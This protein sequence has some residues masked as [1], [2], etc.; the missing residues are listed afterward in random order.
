MAEAEASTIE[1]SYPGPSGP[2]LEGEKSSSGPLKRT[3]T[4]K[5]R[6]RAPSN[7]GSPPGL[8]NDLAACECGHTCKTRSGLA[9]HRKSCGIVNGQ[10]R[11]RSRCQYCDAAFDT[12]IGVRQHERRAHPADY[13]Q[14]LQ[15][16]LDNP[17]QEWEIY[18]TLAGI[19][20]S[21]RKGQPFIAR[22]VE[23]TGLPASK[24]DYIRRRKPVYR[25][26]LEAARS[27]FAAASAGADDGADVSVSGSDSVSILSTL[28]AA[29]LCRHRPHLSLT[30]ALLVVRPDAAPPLCL[31]PRRRAPSPFLL[32]LML[33][34]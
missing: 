26:Y 27:S 30:R 9:R 5:K 25:S 32:T 13:S 16:G 24:I 17:S 33:G 12:F 10:A 6:L 2:T 7:S 21:T 20:A 18:E 14:E 11:N 15:R 22:M 8:N 19:E 4:I 3:G 31:S 23:A 29:S 1:S 28:A 34:R